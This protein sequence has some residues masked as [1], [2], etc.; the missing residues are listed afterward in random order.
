VLAVGAHMKN[1]I[2]LAW[3]DRCVVSPHIGDM[4]SERSMQVFEQV[5]ADLQALYGVRAEAL[6]CDAH[7]GYATARW[8]S[9]SGLPVAKCCTTM[10]MPPRWPRSM[11]VQD[12]CWCSPGTASATAA[13]AALG[14]R[15][16]PRPAR[17]WR[18]SRV[19]G[20]SVCRA[21]SA[22]GASP[23]AARRRCAGKPAAM[24]RLPRPR[25]AGPG[26]WERGLNTPWTS[27]VGRLFDAAAALTGLCLHASYEGEGPMRFEAS[28]RDDLP[29]RPRRCPWPG[30]RM[31]C[32]APT[33]RRCSA[34]ADDASPVGARAPRCST[35]AWP[36]GGGHACE[37]CA[38]A[39]RIARWAP[40]AG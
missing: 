12:R 23:G 10:R 26:A 34:L 32:C 29:A 8:A 15:G 36:D 24:A 7:P 20:R 25:R 31:A 5:A 39:V 38:P 13:T 3:E 4:G 9:R 18:A 35:N 11:P 27:A 28:A 14:W 6:A 40:P 16:V 22:P 33:G 1:T 30:R 21:A 2:A 19:S 37:R 17:R